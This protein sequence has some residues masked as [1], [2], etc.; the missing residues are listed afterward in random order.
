MAIGAWYRKPLPTV[1]TAMALLFA[2]QF[3][4]Q[5]ESVRPW[6]FTAPLQGWTQF[7]GGNAGS[8]QWG[9]GLMVPVVYTLVAMAAA[10]WSVSRRDYVQ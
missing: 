3:V 8:F 4:G 1:M 2:L 5:I 6:L 9:Y 7:L 10:G